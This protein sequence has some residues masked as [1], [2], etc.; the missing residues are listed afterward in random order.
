MDLLEL[1]RGKAGRPVAADPF[2]ALQFRQRAV[3]A[4]EDDVLGSEQVEAVEE[5]PTLAQ[6]VVNHDLIVYRAIPAMARWKPM[7]VRS[8]SACRRSSGMSRSDRIAWKAST[9]M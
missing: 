2:P 8:I 7:A 4:D 9:G 3:N 1:P 5:A 6:H